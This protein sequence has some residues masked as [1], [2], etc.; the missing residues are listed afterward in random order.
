[1][2]R[3]MGN[4]IYLVGDKSTGEAFVIDGAW[5]PDGIE[6]RTTA[7]HCAMPEKRHA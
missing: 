2:A 7:K 4:F 1:M 3:Q 6:V 5:D